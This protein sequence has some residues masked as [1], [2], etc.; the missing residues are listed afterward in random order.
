MAYGTV[1]VDNVT[2]SAGTTTFAGNVKLNGQGDLRLA[3]SD[4]SHYVALQAGAT[5]GTNYTIEF[6]TTVGTTGKVLKSTV[7]GQVAT[8]TWDTLS[9]LD[10]A[11]L[12]G[13]TSIN[14]VEVD[15]YIRINDS[16]D[17]H[18]VALVA[19]ATIGT[20]F[21]LTLPTSPP[22]T[23]NYVLQSTTAGV[24]SW[25]SVSTIVDG[26][27]FANATSVADTSGDVNAGDFN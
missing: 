26:G 7:S 21:N 20:S 18:Y 2:S 12:T 19:P 17:S 13:T 24:L 16:D 11:S 4:S 14:Q 6:P 3:D 10:N 5:V 1:K 25:R 15:G 22:S 8:L 27:N 9:S 23:N